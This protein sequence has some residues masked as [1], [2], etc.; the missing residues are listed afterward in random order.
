MKGVVRSLPYLK[1]LGIETEA[2]CW[3]CDEGLP[4]DRIIK[5]PRYGR[6][7]PL[8]GYAFSFWARRRARQVFRSGGEV[9]PDIIYTIA[10]YLPDCDVCHVHFSPF[11]WERRQQLLGLRSLRDVF[12]RVLNLLGIVTA[13]RFLRRTTAQLLLTVSRAVAGDLEDEKIS[14]PVRVLPN[15]YDAEKFHPGV[16]A[17]FRE[18]TRKRLNF[19]EDT[20]VFVF[21]SAGHYR[22]KGFF[23]AVQS[24]VVLRR[25]CP[26]VKLLVLGGQPARLKALQSRLDQDA[27]GWSDWILFTGMVK[28]MEQYFAAGDALL[29]PSYSEAFALVEVEAAACGLPLFLTRH[30]GSEMIMVD[31]INGRYVEFDAEQIA[32]VL[33]EFV[34]GTWSPSGIVLKDA[35]D[36]DT[37]ARRFADELLMAAGSKSASALS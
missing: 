16:R 12:D 13:R 19:L 24:L 23:L 37:Y 35:M 27:P 9:R 3:D 31:G 14:M 15:S 34:S 7:H 5:L 4:V 2:W 36:S 22:R 18:S 1:S 21:A 28:E 8:G 25:T 30:H 32:G 10:W 11:D 17:A 26:H 20:K 6:L 33:E 29:F